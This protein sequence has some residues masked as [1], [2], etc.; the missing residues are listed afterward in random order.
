MQRAKGVGGDWAGRRRE[1]G[2]VIGKAGR[3]CHYTL[4]KQLM[5]LTS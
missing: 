5:K 2:A 1:G 3:N 4:N